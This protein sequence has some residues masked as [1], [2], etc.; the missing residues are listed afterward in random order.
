M[1]SLLDAREWDY[2][3]G[4]VHFLRDEAVDMRGSDW[5]V[6]R[7]RRPRQG[8]AALLRD[9]RRG[10]PHRHVR[11]PRPPRPREGLGRR[12]PDA[13]RRPAP[14]LRA[15]DG[16]HRRVGRGDR[17]VHGRAAQARGGDLPGRRHSWRCAW[18]PAGRWR[19]PATPTCPRTSATATSR[20]SSGWPSVGVTELAVFEGRERR[21]EPTRMSARSGI[22]YDSHRF[23]EGRR[24]VLGGVEVPEAERGLTGHSDADVLTHAVIDSLLGAAGLGRHRPALPRHRGASGATPTRS[25]CC[26]RSAGSSASTAGPC[27][28][29]TPA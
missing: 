2:V 14:L 29:S 10:R 19:C 1:A 3:V 12:R 22:G 26:R 16:R 13:R 18:R 28:T 25:P 17:G 24:L 8:L 23:G 20:R 9:A 4:S 21:L 11:H 15:G 6:W 7:S 5:D 27:A